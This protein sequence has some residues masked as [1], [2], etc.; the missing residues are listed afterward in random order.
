[1]RLFKALSARR[2]RLPQ[3]PDELRWEDLVGRTITDAFIN[4]AAGSGIKQFTQVDLHFKDGGSVTFKTTSAQH[5]SSWLVVTG[6]S[7]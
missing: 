1:M 6:R 7:A 4:K 2:R 5:A 3:P